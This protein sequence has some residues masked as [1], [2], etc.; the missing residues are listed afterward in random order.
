M[1]GAAMKKVEL[2]TEI[3]QQKNYPGLIAIHYEWK[4]TEDE[5]NRLTR[6]LKNI[7]NGES[8]KHFISHLELYCQDIK[9]I[10]NKPSHAELKTINDDILKSCRKTLK[11]LRK[12]ERGKL[13]L[14]NFQRI[15]DRKRPG[16]N[17]EEKLLLDSLKKAWNVVGP[18]HSFIETAEKI[19]KTL[20]K[21]QGASGQT[22]QVLF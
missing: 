13:P 10:L 7:T 12:V 9:R 2:R 8:L 14:I 18:L 15:P 22:A 20:Q 17:I 11:F 6:E 4:F 3:P 19:Q 21:N 16:E 1:K 5:K